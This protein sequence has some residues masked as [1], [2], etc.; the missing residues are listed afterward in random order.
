MK[1][2]FIGDIVGNVGRQMIEDYLY[3]IRKDY[4][5][6][7]VIANV[8]NATHGKGLNRKHYDFFTFEGVDCMTMGNHTFDKKELL[9][10]I[11]EA[12][13]LVVPFNQ[14][15]ILPGVHTRVFNVKGTKIR[16]TNA[17]GCV[18]MDN[19]Y[20]NPFDHIDDYLNL[21]Q[22]IHIID[23]HAE[24]T[25]EKIGLAYYCK[26]KVQAV[27]GTH[28]H[29]QTAD[30]RIIDKKVAFISDA[31]MTGPYLSSLGCDLDSVIT[32]MRGLSSKF[33]ISENSGQFAGVVIEFNDKHQ[34]I[35][36][37]R[38]LINDDSYSELGGKNMEI[39]KVSS[40]SVPNHVAGA[41]AS[42]MREQ[43]KLM[44]QTIGAA[45]LNQAIK[46]IA[47]ARGYIIP[48]GKELICIPSFHDLMVD[49]KRITA[50][51]LVI[52]LR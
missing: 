43:D 16:V 25:S 46:S 9:D 10:F 7:F 30:E 6:D 15:S 35:S 29:V 39:I 26:D 20:S 4:Q 50:L 11:D 45:A 23:I 33:L 27:L 52:E 17:L 13:R 42:L 49:D 21:E 19:R 47:I 38:V 41:I 32:R 14:P 31:G 3:R 22:D 12:D 36:I 44:I 2:L 51:R 5:I 8:E 40:T 18:F 48:T 24:A 34:P 37:E 28:T 1:V